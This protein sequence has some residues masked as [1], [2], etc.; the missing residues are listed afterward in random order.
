[1]WIPVQSFETV[2]KINRRFSVEEITD[3]GALNRSV[4]KNTWDGIFK[5]I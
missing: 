3:V 5:A 1:M 4:L 2:S